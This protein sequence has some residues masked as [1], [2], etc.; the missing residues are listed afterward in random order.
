MKVLVLFLLCAF[1]SG[2]DR[3]YLKRAVGIRS[4]GRDVLYYVRVKNALRLVLF[5]LCF[6]S[7]KL[8]VLA[9]SFLPFI[10]AVLFTGTFV[11]GGEASALIFTVLLLL[12]AVLFFHAAV[13]FLRFNS[14]FFVSRYC[15]VT[16]RFAKMRDLFRFSFSCMQGNRRTV[17]LKKLSFIPW[18]FSCVLLLPI[19]FVR[20]YYNQSMAYLACDLIEKD[21]QKQ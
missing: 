6:Y 4:D 7:L 1:R 12:C 8:A 15:F 13:F 14:F 16:G 20:S 11:S 19:S 3:F 9:L 18:F 5:Y 10:A 17:F 2:S 21:L